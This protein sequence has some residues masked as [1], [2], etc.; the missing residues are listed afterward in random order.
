[1]GIAY[2]V[3]APFVVASP[4]L[5]PSASANQRPP[6]GRPRCPGGRV[7]RGDEELGGDTRRG[8][9]TDPVV[10]GFGEPHVAVRAGRDA[11]KQAAGRGDWEVGNNT[12]RSDSPDPVAA[13]FG[14]PEVVVRAGADVWELLLAAGNSVTMPAV[15]IRPIWLALAFGEPEVAVR[16]GRDGAP[17]PKNARS[18]GEGAGDDA[19]RRHPPDKHVSCEIDNMNGIGEPDVAIGTGRDTPWA[20][21]ARGV[22]E[23]GDDTG[24][25]DPTNL[26]GTQAFG[27]PDVVV[28]PGRDPKAGCRPLGS[29]TR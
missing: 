25:G 17:E 14:E 27:E 6:S 7:D 21:D 22:W 23:L 20:V 11:G 13:C 28:R 16:A 9:L 8:D 19:G 12:G 3:T 5:L 4:I 26:V 18:D 1:M 15:V 2:S 24:R 29:G 10:I